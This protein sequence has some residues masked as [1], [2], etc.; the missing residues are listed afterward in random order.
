MSRRKLRVELP[1][2]PEPG[3]GQVGKLIDGGVMGIKGWCV[4]RA[5]N[6]HKKRRMETRTFVEERAK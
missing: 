1:V 6:G 2:C 5:G 3:C 4:G